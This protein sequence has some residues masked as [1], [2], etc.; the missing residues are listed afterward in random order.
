MGV[1]TVD[2]ALSSAPRWSDCQHEW[3]EVESQ[4]NNERYTSVTC[5]KCHCPGER[6]ERTG[7]VFWPAT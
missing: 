2:K 1:G 5:K 7:E 3:K 6:D 4:W